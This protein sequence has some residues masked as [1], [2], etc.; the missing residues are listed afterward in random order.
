[1]KTGLV[2]DAGADADLAIHPDVPD[3]Q[4]N[5]RSPLEGAVVT[6]NPGLVEL[7]LKHGAKIDAEVSR[8]VPILHRLAAARLEN[9]YGDPDR[10]A[11]ID[12]DALAIAK[13]LVAAGADP[14]AN[15]EAEQTSASAARFNM[16]G[17]TCTAH[18]L[19]TALQED[20]PLRDYLEQVMAPKREALTK[21]YRETAEAFVLAALAGDE[22]ALRAQ[23][24]A[25]WVV[26]DPVGIERGLS[27][28]VPLIQRAV[29]FDPEDEDAELPIVAV[30]ARLNEGAVLL[31]NKPGAAM[32]YTSVLIVRVGEGWRVMG[33]EQFKKDDAMI[34]IKRAL[35]H[36]KEAI[37]FG[38][39]HETGDLPTPDPADR[40]RRTSDRG[41]TAVV[42]SVDDGGQ[43]TAEWQNQRGVNPT[44]LLNHP[45]TQGIVHLRPAGVKLYHTLGKLSYHEI[46]LTRNRVALPDGT[47]FSVNADGRLLVQE[48][49]QAPQLVPGDRVDISLDNFT[50]RVR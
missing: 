30:E 22:D 21:Q 34:P 42:L 29:D 43:L 32:P 15:V 5:A 6:L 12:R 31:R 33:S 23:T 26:N 27:F 28:S 37:D 11:P 9:N 40:G 7:L 14:W 18:D 10:Q 39:Y 47:R 46:E 2:L 16:R 48:Q 1:M 49:E 44:T 8:G 17:M 24:T 4:V 50:Y 35:L 45:A 41:N 19:L 13:L 20:C 38:I 3:G 36:F 25:A